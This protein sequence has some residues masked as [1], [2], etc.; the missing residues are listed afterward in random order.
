MKTKTLKKLREENKLT[1]KQV[2][3]FLGITIQYLSYLENG[4]RNPSDKLKEKMSSLYRCTIQDIFLA[5]KSTKC[6]KIK[7]KKDLTK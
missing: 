7:I 1:Q 3:D 4:V 5:V 2:A 6:W